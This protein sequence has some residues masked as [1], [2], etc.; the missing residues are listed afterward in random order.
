MG[1]DVLGN[2]LFPGVI[3]QCVCVCVCVRA[4]VR[5]RACVCVCVRGEGG[6]NPDKVYGVIYGLDIVVLEFT[7]PL[8]FFCFLFFSLN[9][10]T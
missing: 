4:C 10:N 1:K 7:R 8:C 2:N 5:A 9:Y 3:A 6:G